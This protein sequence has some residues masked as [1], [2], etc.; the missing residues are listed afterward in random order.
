MYPTSIGSSTMR[1]LFVAAAAAIAA[2]A[3]QTAERPVELKRG[4]GRDKVVAHCSA[5]HSLDYILVNSGFLDAA[6]WNAEVAKMINAFGAPVDQAD[7]KAIAEY[8]A[9]NYGPRPQPGGPRAGDGNPQ[10]QRFEARGVQPSA[11]E[12]LGSRRSSSAQ[13]SSFARGA[14]GP[15][16]ASR[17]RA[18]PFGALFAMFVE[19][20]TCRH[21]AWTAACET[22]QPAEP[23]RRQARW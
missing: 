22:R 17:R 4:D 2:T 8:L 1:W 14:R 23:G 18:G 10:R 19:P 20:S 21:R 12:R 13:L 15:H 16:A 9:T 11:P 3:A 5:C 6:G 7:A